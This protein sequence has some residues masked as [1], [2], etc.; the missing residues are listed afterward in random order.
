MRAPRAGEER[1]RFIPMMPVEEKMSSGDKVTSIVI[2]GRHPALI[3]RALDAAI[4]ASVP[5]ATWLERRERELVD[6]AHRGGD[7]C[8]RCC[9]DVVGQPA[10]D[11]G[12]IHGHG[13]RV[14]HISATTSPHGASSTNARMPMMPS[15]ATAR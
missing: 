4:D 5:D 9:G 6:R 7:R 12:E 15:V 13:R 14:E 2:C 1:D 3:R 10:G 11:G 8:R